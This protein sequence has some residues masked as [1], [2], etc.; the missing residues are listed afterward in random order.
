[1]A[2]RSNVCVD[3][4]F[5]LQSIS[6]CHPCQSIPLLCPNGPRGRRRGAEERVNRAFQRQQTRLDVEPAGEPGQPAGGSDHPMARRND[7]H[8]IS[9]VCRADRAHGARAARSASRSARRIAFLRTG[10]SATRSTPCV[11]T[12]SRPDPASTRTPSARPAKY[13]SSW[14]SVSTSTGCRSS[15]ASMFSRTRPGRSFS[16]RIAASPSS[17]ATSV[18]LPTGESTVL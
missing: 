4:F 6:D 7:R 13:S 5:A 10:S 14:R 9:A 16:H 18:S 12:P 3:M 15:S 2:G 1:M 8:R 17:V 11:E